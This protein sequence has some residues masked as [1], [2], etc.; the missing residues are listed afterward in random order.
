[1]AIVAVVVFSGA[2]IIAWLGRER[3]AVEFGFTEADADPAPSVAR[4]G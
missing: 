4:S 1:M 2:A 3:H